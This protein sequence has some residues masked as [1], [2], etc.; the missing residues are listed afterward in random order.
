M[1]FIK[2]VFSRYYDIYENLKDQINSSETDDFVEEIINQIKDLIEKFIEKEIIEIKTE[3]E[4][5]TEEDFINYFLIF[6]KALR[7]E[8]FRKELLEIIIKFI[9]NFEVFIQKTP[10]IIIDKSFYLNLREFIEG[11][12]S[13]EPKK[14]LRCLFSYFKKMNEKIPVLTIFGSLLINREKKWKEKE[15][16]RIL[17]IEDFLKNSNSIETIIEQASETLF[18]QYVFDLALKFGYLLEA[19]I[20]NIL[21]FILEI[22]YIKNDL[23]FNAFK[24]E[25]GNTIGDILH[26]FKK[27]DI[28][29]NRIIKD[30]R[31]AIFHSDFY[32]KYDV[33]ME[34]REI[35]IRTLIYSKEK[36]KKVEKVYYIKIKDFFSYFYRMIILCF[37]VDVV[38]FTSFLKDYAIDKLN[39]FF[40]TTIPEFLNSLKDISADDIQKLLEENK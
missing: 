35:N 30:Y 15:L 13:V 31:N 6:L 17:S 37:T 39:N 12:L 22:Y 14:T 9:N 21:M 24:E 8:E 5:I 19:H 20:K 23:N 11:A 3:I 40:D 1:K 29:L 38:I 2:K 18:T 25:N 16:K 32:L 33:D 28:Y 27:E 7:N 36:S 4:T 34:K 26:A 10:Q